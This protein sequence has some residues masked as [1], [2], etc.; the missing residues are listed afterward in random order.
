MLLFDDKLHK[1]EHTSSPKPV[2]PKHNTR[3]RH[4][5]LSAFAAKVAGEDNTLFTSVFAFQEILLPTEARFVFLEFLLR[6]PCAI[7][8]Q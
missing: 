8:T 4:T 1:L 5:R 7:I 3:I 6:V 2:L